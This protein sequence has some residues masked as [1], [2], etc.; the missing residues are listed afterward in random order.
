MLTVVS[1]FFFVKCLLTF[2]I[3]ACLPSHAL[4]LYG[5][6]REKHVAELAQMTRNAELEALAKSQA[7]KTAE[8]EKRALV[9]GERKRM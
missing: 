3:N 9:C 6:R 2:T 5:K 4:V 8:L 1:G 7:D